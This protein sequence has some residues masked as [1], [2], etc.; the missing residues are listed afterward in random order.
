MQILSPIQNRPHSKTYDKCWLQIRSPSYSYIHRGY[1]LCVS[2]GIFYL[3]FHCLSSH[4][5]CLEMENSWNRKG[6]TYRWL[7]HKHNPKKRVIFDLHLLCLSPHTV[8]LEREWK[9]LANNGVIREESNEYLP[10]STYR[11]LELEAKN[12]K[13]T[14]GDILSSHSLLVLSPSLSVYK[15]FSAQCDADFASVKYQ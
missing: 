2:Q 6:G 15:A 4:I 9:I 13:Q 10:S 11:R 7:E 5:V 14:T 8:C 1:D 12:R 3:H